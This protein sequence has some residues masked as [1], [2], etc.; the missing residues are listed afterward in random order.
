MTASDYGQ[1]TH[2][3]CHQNDQ[4]LMYSLMKGGC[5]CILYSDMKIEF[6]TCTHGDVLLNMCSHRR[7]EV[8][9]M[10]VQPTDQRALRE[11]SLW[12]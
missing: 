12:K 6:N 11:V 9:L 4:G 5:T 1:L 8:K 2:I 7:M 3:P 10:T